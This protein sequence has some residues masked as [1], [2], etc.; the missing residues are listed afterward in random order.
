MTWYRNPTA[1]LPGDLRTKWSVFKSHL[2]SVVRI[3]RTTKWH[4]LSAGFIRHRWNLMLECVGNYPW[5][6][7]KPKGKD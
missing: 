7:P 4:K 6:A 5:R 1:V 2:S 3:L